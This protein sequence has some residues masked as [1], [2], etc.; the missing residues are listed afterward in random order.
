MRR[1]PVW[2]FEGVGPLVLGMTRDEVRQ[3]IGSNFRQFRKVP[4]APTLS[5]QFFDPLLVVFYECG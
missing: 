3:K 5:D 1:F 2:S 4:T